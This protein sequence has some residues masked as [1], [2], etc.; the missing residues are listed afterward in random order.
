MPSYNFYNL[1]FDRLAAWLTPKV[2]RKSKLGSLVTA[3]LF[4]LYFLH[5]SF[6]KYRKAKHYQTD[7]TSQKCYLERLLNDRFDSSLRRIEIGDA[8]WHL[9]IF[10]FQEAEEKPEMLFQDAE[11]KPK[12]LFKEEE[13]GDVKA[14]FVVLVPAAIS[15]AE[16]EMKGLLDSYKLTGTTYTIQKI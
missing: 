13:A 11:E 10:L 16:P 15:F 2:L 4:P 6:L 9:P 5:N 3:C 7:I 12:Y 1:D 8:E 14:D